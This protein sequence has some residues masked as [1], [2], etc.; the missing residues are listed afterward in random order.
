MRQRNICWSRP[1]RL[2]TDWSLIRWD[3]IISIAINMAHV[4]LFDSSPSWSRVTCRWC[5][6]C[7]VRSCSTKP[8][9]WTAARTDSPKNIWFLSAYSPHSISCCW[10]RSNHAST[11]LTRSL[12]RYWTALS[13]RT[14]LD[15]NDMCTNDRG[16][17]LLRQ[18]VRARPDGS[19]LPAICIQN[20][21][22]LCEELSKNKIVTK[23]FAEY[24]LVDFVVLVKLTSLP[25]KIKQH[26]MPGVYSIMDTCTEYE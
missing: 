1:A 22:R 18:I 13:V 2:W 5:C 8:V 23:K 24:F 11:R 3:L 12:H 21:S 16:A 19:Y 26:L 20:F 6:S 14:S 10:T 15:T 4:Y 9:Q 17:D 25:P 7:S